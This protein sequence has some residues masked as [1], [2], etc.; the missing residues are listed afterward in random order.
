MIGGFSI[1]LFWR[2]ITRCSNGS[3]WVRERGASTQLGQAKIDDSEL[4]RRHY[5]HC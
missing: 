5:H 3:A 4:W 1:H 2:H